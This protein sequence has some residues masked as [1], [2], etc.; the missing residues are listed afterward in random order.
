M[1]QE[2]VQGL[3]GQSR[4]GDKKAFE[5]LV[6]E[7]Q[8]TVFRLAFRLL[9]NEDEAKDI[10]QETFIKIWQNL[11]KYRA[12]YSFKTWIYRIASNLCYDSLRTTKYRFEPIQENFHPVS[13]ENVEQAIINNDLKSLIILFTEQLTPKQKMIFTLSEIEELSVEEIATITR[14]SPAKIKSNLYLA[15]KQ[16]KEKMNQINI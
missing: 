15:K 12:Q 5:K 7:Y 1:L 8:A 11:D 13:S 10:V 2:Q 3:I 9:C 6:A 4:I 16:I 14:L